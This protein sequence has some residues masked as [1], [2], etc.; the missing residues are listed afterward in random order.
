[1]PFEW[2]VRR[3]DKRFR[4][5]LDEPVKA[6]FLGQSLVEAGE[7]WPYGQRSH[8]LE[9]V[10]EAIRDLVG[11]S[12]REQI[13]CAIGLLMRDRLP[14]HLD[15]PCGSS[16]RLRQCHGPKIWAIHDVSTVAWLRQFPNLPAS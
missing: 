7:P 16:R 13:G 6:Y 15:C 9:G 12:D 11:L 8:G 2:K 4:T 1:V 10:A 14:G 5:F 3:P